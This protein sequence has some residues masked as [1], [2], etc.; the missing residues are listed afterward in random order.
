MTHDRMLHTATLAAEVP[1]LYPSFLLVVKHVAHNHRDL[2]EH[3]C[4]SMNS[5]LACRVC[6]QDNTIL[7]DA[8]VN[9][10]LHRHQRS[11]SGSHLSIEKQD[12]LVVCNVIG[13]PE[14]VKLRLSR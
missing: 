9:Q 13:Q 7:L 8:M 1:P 10:D 3:G 2:W 6:C 5:N 11:T 12:A 14:V 4:Q